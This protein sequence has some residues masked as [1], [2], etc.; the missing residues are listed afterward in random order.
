MRYTRLV[1]DI[2]ETGRVCY[3]H[4]LEVGARGWID[5]R[6]KGF[7]AFLCHLAGVKKLRQVQRN[8]SKLALLGS[9]VIYNARNSMEWAGGDL[10]RP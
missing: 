6:N 10:L 9:K 7:L 1:E 8:C 2:R 5:S 3:L 4:T